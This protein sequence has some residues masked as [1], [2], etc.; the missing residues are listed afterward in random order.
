MRKGRTGT[1][2]G[3][4]LAAC[5]VVGGLLVVMGGDDDRRVHRELGRK[6]NGVKLDGFD[7]FWTCALV[8]AD[9]HRV[10]SNADL[11]LELARRVDGAGAE[12]AVHLRDNCHASLETVAPELDALI[13]HNDD[14]KTE[15]VAMSVAATELDAAFRALSNVMLKAA[16]PGVTPAS[17]AQLKKIARAWYDFRRA[18]GSA[19]QLLKE[20]LD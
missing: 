3:L 2:V 17:E 12:Y 4:V 9:Y 5:A 18:Y 6:I 7:R 10:K 13:V 15:V 19:N 14:L 20:R 8:G 1:L 16:E 11:T